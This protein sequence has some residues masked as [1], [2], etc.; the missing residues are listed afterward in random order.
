[1]GIDVDCSSMTQIRYSR[2]AWSVALATLPA[3]M[4]I[5]CGSD[6]VHTNDDSPSTSA[7]AGSDSGPTHDTAP[8]SSAVSSASA[9]PSGSSAAADAGPTIEVTKDSVL[10][11]G[12]MVG[13]VKAIAAMKTAP[14]IDNLVD[15]MKHVRQ[16]FETAKPGAPFSGRC[17]IHAAADVPPIV[18]DAILKSAG[19]A[20]FKCA[21]PRTTS[22]SGGLELT[23]RNGASRRASLVVTY[24][25]C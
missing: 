15:A 9:P 7:P 16:T 11:Q 23:E 19:E 6:Q 3:L 4:Q 22:N 20:G 12:N 8:P 13:S 24:C 1:M 25:V 21:D 14:K 5:G 18:I 10:F 2:L 17:T